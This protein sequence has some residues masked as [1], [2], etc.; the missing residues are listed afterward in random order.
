MPNPTVSYFDSPR[1]RGEELRL[2]FVL[3]GVPFNDNR[4]DNDGV[5]AMKPDLPFAAL[6]VLDVPGQG[7]FAQT[8]AMLRLVGRLHGLY[9]EDPY[10]GAR[11]DAVMEAAEELRQ[12]LSAT[13][14]IADPDLRKQ[15]R[16]SLSR[17][18]IPAWARG[19]EAQIGAGPFVNGAGPGVADIKLFVLEQALADATFDHVPAD[20]LA[21]YPRLI[22]AARGV[23]AHPAVRAWYA[24]TA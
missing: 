14:R 16:D 8:N 2:A 5:A 12:R 21:P 6:P 15:A 11:Q 10:A 23:G 4:L 19:I 20:L 7:R 18:F 3:A 17:D 13:T 24:R 9:P 1:S 22:A